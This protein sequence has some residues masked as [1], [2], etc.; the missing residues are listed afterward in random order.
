MLSSIRNAILLVTLAFPAAAMAGA[1]DTAAPT[2]TKD[3]PAATTAT[4]TAKPVA[5][6]KKHKK[7]HKAPKAPATPAPTTTP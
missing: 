2:P 3:A 1:P 7:K 6:K 5:K 4:T